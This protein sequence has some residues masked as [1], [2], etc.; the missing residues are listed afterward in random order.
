MILYGASALTLVPFGVLYALAVQYGWDHTT[1]FVV[2]VALG[3]AI[4]L[5]VWTWLEGRIVGRVPRFS[6]ANLEAVPASH[7][8]FQFGVMSAGQANNE[9]VATG[10]S[11]MYK[12]A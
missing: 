1:L 10:S 7:T 11:V 4:A 8:V 2:C 3:V 5:M 6:V 9:A 12:A